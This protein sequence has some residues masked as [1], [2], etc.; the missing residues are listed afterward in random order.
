[1]LNHVKKTFFNPLEEVDL[2]EKRA[3]MNDLLN[4]FPVQGNL[5]LVNSSFEQSKTMFGNPQ[6]K[7]IAGYQCQK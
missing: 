6:T 5:N 4:S 2:E 1:M 3:I 7:E